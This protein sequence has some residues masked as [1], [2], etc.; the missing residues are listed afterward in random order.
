MFTKFTI[1]CNLYDRKRYLA[2][3]TNIKESLF[4]KVKMFMKHVIWGQKVVNAD[5]YQVKMHDIRNMHAKYDLWTFY[6][7]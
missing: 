6:N 2:E 1:P 7:L 4:S 3:M 5:W